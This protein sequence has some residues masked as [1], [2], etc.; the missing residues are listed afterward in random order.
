[1][2]TRARAIPA[3]DLSGIR[4]IRVAASFPPEGALGAMAGDEHRV[5]THWPQALLDAGD[6]RVM[7]ALRKIGAPD[8]ARKQHI[9]HKGPLGLA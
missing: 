8:R 1:M 7:I 4:H 6:Q 3:T 5:V 2:S 9:S